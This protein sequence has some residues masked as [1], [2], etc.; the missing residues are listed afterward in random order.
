MLKDKID[1]L[2]IDK[3]N[4]ITPND[5]RRNLNAHFPHYTEEMYVAIYAAYL[6]GFELEFYQGG[7]VGIDN[8]SI[9][10]PIGLIKHIHGF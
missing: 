1:S 2:V 6:A 8:I 3:K 4:V 7:S 9:S 10:S 5:L